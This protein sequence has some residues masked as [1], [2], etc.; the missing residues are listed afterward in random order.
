MNT[1]QRAVRALGILALLAMGLFPPCYADDAKYVNY[2]RQMKASDVDPQLPAVPFDQWLSSVLPALAE[3][4]WDANDCG[5]SGDREGAV[6]ICVG[7]QA[8]LSTCSNVHI[9]VAVGTSEKGIED[10]PEFF[11]GV[12]RGF[13][14]EI[15]VDRLR[16]LPEQLKAADK[17]GKAFSAIPRKAKEIDPKEAIEFAKALAVSRLDENLPNQTVEAWFKGLKGIHQ[18]LS[19]IFQACY[20][21]PFTNECGDCA[22][23]VTLK[24]EDSEKAILLSLVVGT[25]RRGIVGDP[26]VERTTFWNKRRGEGYGITSVRLK[27]LPKKLTDFEQSAEERR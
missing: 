18:P 21:E 23:T 6:P 7:V 9:N 14:P 12:I 1:R 22:A 10:K 27:D 8:T 17:A 16:N 11:F 26:I 20:S 19:W 15:L 3:T 4:T 13:G 24:Y 25:Y 2:L 5:E